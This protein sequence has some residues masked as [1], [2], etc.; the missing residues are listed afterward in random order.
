[1]TS[2]AVFA[3]VWTG[4]Y[5]YFFYDDRDKFG[6]PISFAVGFAVL[7]LIITLTFHACSHL[8]RVK[9]VGADAIGWPVRRFFWFAFPVATAVG[10]GLGIW[11]AF[12]WFVKADGGTDGQIVFVSLVH[13]ANGALL[14]LVFFAVSSFMMRRILPPASPL[15][16]VKT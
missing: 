15:A 14:A 6:Q 13:A 8:L 2:Y 12:A 11:L 7:P 16:A 9:H 5:G 4:V 1:M 10:F 3:I